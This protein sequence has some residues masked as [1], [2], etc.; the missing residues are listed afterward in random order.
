MNL[1]ATASVLPPATVQTIGHHAVHSGA[2][3][4][5]LPENYPASGSITRLPAPEPGTP[6]LQTCDYFREALLTIV[7]VET[8]TRTVQHSHHIP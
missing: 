2:S 4:P 7:P 1:S 3:T 8:G 6:L 5:Y